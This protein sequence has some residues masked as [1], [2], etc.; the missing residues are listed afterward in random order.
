MQW[1]GC[2]GCSV[3]CVVAVVQWEA[4]EGLMKAKTEELQAGK[5]QLEAG[6][7]TSTSSASFGER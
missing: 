2:C 7:E 3:S 1:S 6:D 5:K 4:Q